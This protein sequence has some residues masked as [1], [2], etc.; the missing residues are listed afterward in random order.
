[1]KKIILYAILYFL[2]LQ[3]SNAGEVEFSFFEPSGKP[4]AYLAP[5]EEMSIY[6]WSGEPVAYIDVEKQ[7]GPHVYGYNGE[8][9]GWFEKGAI[10]NKDG[11]VAC[12]SKEMLTRADY[13]PYKS[14]K[15]YKPYRSYQS[16]PPRKPRFSLSP[17]PISCTLHLARGQ[18]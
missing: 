9:L 13:E 14:Y 18:K 5:S 6:L 3:Q 15:E 8:H 12:A 4:V 7:D 17:S 10:F 1:M 11:K 16:R 2:P